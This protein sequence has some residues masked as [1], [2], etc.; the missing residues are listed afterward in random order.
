MSACFAQLVWRYRYVATALNF[1]IIVFS[2]SISFNAAPYYL[3]GFL[4][5][6]CFSFLTSASRLWSPFLEVRNFRGAPDAAHMTLSWHA[7]SFLA[8]NLVPRLLSTSGYRMARLTA[9]SLILQ[10][11]RHSFVV[12]RHNHSFL[13]RF[14]GTSI[15]FTLRDSTGAIA[16]TAA[17]TIQNSSQ[18]SGD[19]PSLPLPNPS[20]LRSHDCL[21]RRASLNSQSPCEYRLYS[22]P[23]SR[24]HLRSNIQAW[25]Q[26][27]CL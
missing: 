10:P 3:V 27:A 25:D 19:H 5:S 11:V 12:V 14:A 4:D 26:C 13:T 16:Q 6:S 24:H 2:R 7:A 22:R 20:L 8:A 18:L 9:G 1:L 17:V 21:Y 23:A 15:G